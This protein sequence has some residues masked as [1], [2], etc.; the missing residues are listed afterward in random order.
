MTESLIE[1]L[2]RWSG[3][4]LAT[5]LIGGAI[6]LW[7][8]SDQIGALQQDVNTLQHDL[9][10]LKTWTKDPVTGPITRAEEK[11]QLDVVNVRLRRLEKE[12]DPNG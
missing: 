3:G 5:V 7:R 4:I 10:T 9:T 8:L 12:D 6:G 1:R 2:N 11:G